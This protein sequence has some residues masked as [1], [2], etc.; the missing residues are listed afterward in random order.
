LTHL[1]CSYLTAWH[2][3]SNIDEKVF[4]L[5]EHISTIQR[6][7]VNR[8]CDFHVL[9]GIQAFF[10]NVKITE[11]KNQSKSIFRT[12]RQDG[13]AAEEMMTFL[14]QFFLNHKCINECLILNWY[15]Y[16]GVIAYKGY[17]LAKS[18]ATSFINSISITNTGK[19]NIEDS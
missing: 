8:N 13:S 6:Y 19:I 9:I 2:R 15:N 12:N 16:K 14:L 3:K 17:E 5:N 4:L 7:L 18:L 10:H 11:H 1:V